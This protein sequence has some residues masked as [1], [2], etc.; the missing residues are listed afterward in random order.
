MNKLLI[1]LSF[2]TLPLTGLKSQDTIRYA[3]DNI[4]LYGLILDGD[5]LLLSSIDEVYI[6]PARRFSS[7]WEYRRYR[8]LIRNVKKAY[9]YAVLAKKK[10]D[11]ITL[12]FETLNG[13]KA[14]RKYI[15]QVEKELMDEFEDELKQLTI[16]QGRILIKLIDREIGDTSYDLLKE[17][18]GSF[19]AFFWQTIARIFG[20]NLKSEFDPVGEDRLINEIVIMIERG[21]L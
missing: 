20:S 4:V 1:F 13:E 5:T 16:T 10:F 17:L 3:K 9:P 11:E 18:K 2:I 8:R 14:K 19:T 6:F 21:A 12:H 15:K 7:N